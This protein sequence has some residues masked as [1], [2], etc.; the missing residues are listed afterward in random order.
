MVF[1]APALLLA[2]FV[3]IAAMLYMQLE[4]DTRGF[5]E[6]PSPYEADAER[7]RKMLEERSK[8]DKF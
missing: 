7:K 4:H 8:E 6:I 3:P 1:A 2:G 5:S